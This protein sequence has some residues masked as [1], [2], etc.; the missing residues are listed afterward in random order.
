MKAKRNSTCTSA[1]ILPHLWL[2]LLLL[3][4]GG[5][6]SGSI[7]FASV[8]AFVAPIPVPT[9][10]L[11]SRTHHRTSHVT[12]MTRD[13]P[14]A[15]SVGEKGV[16]ATAAATFVGSVVALGAMLFAAT[17]RS[18]DAGL[19]DEGASTPAKSLRASLDE[20]NTAKRTGVGVGR[21]G[22]LLTLAGSALSFAVGDLVLNAAVTAAGGAV[23]AGSGMYER[24]LAFGNRYKGTGAIASEELMAWVSAQKVAATPEIRAWLA[25]QRRLQM[26]RKTA[27]A[28]T[29]AATR[30][31]AAVA[32]GGVVEE[33]MLARAAAATAAANVMSSTNDNSTTAAREAAT[34]TSLEATT[35][36]ANE[37]DSETLYALSSSNALNLTVTTTC[38]T[39]TAA[40]ES[41]HL[42]A[43]T[44][45][46]TDTN[47]VAGTLLS[48]SP[49]I[50]TTN[51]SNTN[52]SS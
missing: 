4:F 3:S 9:R 32:T 7:S 46:C 17:T 23:A 24:V 28:A 50:T 15:D 14:S 8:E 27:V 31:R 20:A 37:E 48:S 44:T 29:A 41:S 38:T 11:A 52:L 51:N 22:T 30:T 47:D 6:R 18:G 25:A 16:A 19:E 26:F 21:R 13:A 36:S 39:S 40:E 10:A 12:L 5:G 49:S 33:G 43:S 35:G 45:T 34:T 2:T 1:W 42:L